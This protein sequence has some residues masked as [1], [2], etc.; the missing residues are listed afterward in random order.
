MTGAQTDYHTEFKWELTK[1]LNKYKKFH[2][3]TEQ[4]RRRLMLLLSQMR[5]VAD[6]T[7]ILEQNLIYGFA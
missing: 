3:M 5:M 7:F 2:Y 4:D 1:I 6:S